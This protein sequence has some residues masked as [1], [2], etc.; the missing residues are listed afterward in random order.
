M[1]YLEIGRKGKPGKYFYQELNAA[2]SSNVTL[3]S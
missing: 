3:P 2:S 1:K